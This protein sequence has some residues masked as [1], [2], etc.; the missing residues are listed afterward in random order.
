MRAFP[1]PWRKELVHF[2]CHEYRELLWKS[3]CTTC[4]IPLHI[5]LH[6]ASLWCARLD[7]VK[8]GRLLGFSRHLW[9]FICSMGVWEMTFGSFLRTHATN[10]RPAESGESEWASHTSDR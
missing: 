5:S 2:L 3:H 8:P 6:I 7:M 1:H 9:Q 10:I 4:D